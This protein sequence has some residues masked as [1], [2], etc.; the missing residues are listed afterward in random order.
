MTKSITKLTTEQEEQLP[1][2]RQKWIDI[3]LSQEPIDYDKSVENITAQY[4]QVGLA[5]PEFKYSRSPKESKEILGENYSSD[6]AC[7]GHHDAGWLCFYDYFKNEVGLDCINPLGNLIELS[8][9]CGWWYPFDEL[10]V[11][12][13]RPKLKMQDMPDGSGLKWC[14]SEDSLAIEYPDGWGIAVVNGKRIPVSE[15]IT[16]PKS[17]TLK[18]IQSS[19]DN[20]LISILIDRYGW[21]KYLE[22]TNSTIIDSR[23]NHI[24]NT[25]EALYSTEKMGRRLIVTCPTGRIFALPVT[26]DVMTCTAAQDFIGDITTENIRPNVIART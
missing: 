16:N 4:K 10:C 15:W 11:I 26:S 19:N 9:V 2:Y 6:A 3:G 12:E 1:I 17:I 20:D 23:I 18:D 24:D 7:Y 21:S 5:I 8:K 25:I 14:H 13:E 22:D